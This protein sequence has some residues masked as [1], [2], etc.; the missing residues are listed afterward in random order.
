MVTSFFSLREEGQTKHS[1]IQK[2]FLG[3]RKVFYTLWRREKRSTPIDRKGEKVNMPPGQ[4]S[5]LWLC[6]KRGWGVVKDNL[7]KKNCRDWLSQT[8]IAIWFEKRCS[9]LH[10]TGSYELWQTHPTSVRN[11]VDFD[12]WKTNSPHE[13]KK[14]SF[15]PLVL[16]RSLRYG[17]IL[18]ACTSYVKK[19]KIWGFNSCRS[20]MLCFIVCVH[21]NS[22]QQT[23][24]LVSS[25]DCYLDLLCRNINFNK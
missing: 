13:C 11:C 23:S 24:L 18:E 2:L 6:K 7:Q 5:A 9:C 12:K 10:A 22:I 20:P 25:S 8:N 4:N 21:R 14:L 16:L 3:L 17:W 1:W 19:D 15:P